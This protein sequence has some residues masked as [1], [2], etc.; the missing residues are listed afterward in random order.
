MFPLI[1]ARRRHS[2]AILLAHLRHIFIHVTCQF[3][4]FFII[5]LLHNSICSIQ[6]HITVSDLQNN[7]I[8]K[9]AA[10]ATD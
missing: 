9:V 4:L 5:I 1:I 3:L 6:S 10:A 8:K 7:K 2:I